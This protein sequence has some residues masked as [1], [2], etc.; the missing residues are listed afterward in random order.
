MLSYCRLTSEPVITTV[1]SSS[2]FCHILLSI[3][4]RFLLEQYLSGTLFPKPV[5]TRIPSP[6]SRRSSI[7][8][9][10]WCTHPIVVICESGLTIIGLEL[11]YQFFCNTDD[12]SW[13][14]DW[15]MVCPVAR[16]LAR[17]SL[18]RHVGLRNLIL[19]RDEWEGGKEYSAFRAALYKLGWSS[20]FKPVSSILVQ[21]HSELTRPPQPLLFSCML[22]PLQGHHTWLSFHRFCHRPTTGTHNGRSWHMTDIASGVS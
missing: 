14:G 5:S 4:I 15:R 10:E 12:V 9:P 3:S 19:Q 21:Q 8:R 1:S 18:T 17:G 2:I 20:A 22:C 16:R 6:H 11:C 7:T 13:A